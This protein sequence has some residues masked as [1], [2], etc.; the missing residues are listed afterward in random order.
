[1]RPLLLASSIA[2]G[3]VRGVVLPYL[4]TLIKVFRAHLEPIRDRGDDGGHLPGAE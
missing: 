3:I 1:M 4:S 2:T